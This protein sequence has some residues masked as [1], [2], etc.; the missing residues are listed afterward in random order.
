MIFFVLV[1]NNKIIGFSFYFVSCWGIEI[2]IFW[3]ML[4]S[5]LVVIIIYKFLLYRI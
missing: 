3:F 5:F 2:Y 4:I 1:I